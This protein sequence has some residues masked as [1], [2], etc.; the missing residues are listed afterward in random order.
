MKNY[1]K[2]FFQKTNKTWFV[3]D[4]HFSHA[5]IIPYTNRPYKD[6]EE[7]NNAIVSIWN[8]SVKSED[9][10]YLLG[11]VSLNIRYVEQYVPKLNGKKI[12]IVGN[13]ENCFEKYP[14]YKPEKMKNM[15][16]RYLNAGFESL[17]DNL[18]ISI[19][20]Y[21]VQ[22]NHFP[23]A[24]KS[25]DKSNGD[26]RYLKHRPID[27]GQILLH[28]HSHAYH[29]KNGR[30]IDVGFDGDLKLW[31]EDEIIALIEDPR[32]YIPSP[33]TEYYNANKE[34]LILKKEEV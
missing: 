9:T 22:L 34:K 8:N 2:M 4:L 24:P 33:I 10:V 15:R 27:K 25:N 17:H 19:G 28:G 29:R 6:I 31:S 1:F 23:F 13:H 20:K 26:I 30:M 11:D 16:Q 21:K 3:G 14:D 18:V 12:L 7:M 5:N 32:D